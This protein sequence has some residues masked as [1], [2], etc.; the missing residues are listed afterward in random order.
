MERYTASMTPSRRC[1][2]GQGAGSFDRAHSFT[3]K[4]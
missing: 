3:S 1:N 4:R 2:E